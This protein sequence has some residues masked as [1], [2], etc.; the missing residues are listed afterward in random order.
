MATTGYLDEILND[1]LDRIG[2]GETVRDC[3]N[4]YPLAAAE[5][6]P[7]LQISA[8]TMRTADTIEY[9]PEAKQRSYYRFT[10]ALADRNRPV[11]ESRFAR[12]ARWWRGGLAKPVTATL[13]VMLLLSGSAFGTVKASE[14]SVPGDTLYSVKK[15]KEDL[16]LM[17]PKS[18]VS[19]AKEHVQL[20]SARSD[21]IT[22][23]VGQGRYVEAQEMVVDVTYH[24]NRSAQLVGITVSINPIEMP[25][26]PVA[27][28]QRGD[29][30]ELVSYVRRD[31]DLYRDRFQAQMQYLTP[32][33]QWY[34]TM[35]MYRWELN[36]RAFLDALDSE[37]P[38]SWPMWVTEPASGYYR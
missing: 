11:Q 36:Y 18:D 28:P 30:A 23:L 26:R 12:F 5:L 25:R 20:A 32:E 29:A 8:A 2:R 37:G 13:G 1:C 15:M 4:S 3:L 17:M 6:V 31:G 21:E 9:R 34:V 24:L 19:L 35:L 14:G 22:Q 38:A 16:S 10:Q 27:R 7:L 33:E